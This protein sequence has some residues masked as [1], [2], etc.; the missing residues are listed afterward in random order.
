LTAPRASFLH[1]APGIAEGF[2]NGDL[3]A[4]EGHIGDDHCPAHAPDDG[5]GVVD[6]LLQRHR[7]GRLVPL[8]HVAKRI[9]HQD[10]VHPCLIE[11]ARHQ[12]IV[13]SQADNLLPLLLHLPQPQ[14]R[15]AAWLLPL[16]CRRSLFLWSAHGASRS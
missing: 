3:V 15:N 6:H 9:A 4:H 2:L 14:R 13:G 12:G 1:N 8:E 10:D 5:F 16:L 7:N 11:D